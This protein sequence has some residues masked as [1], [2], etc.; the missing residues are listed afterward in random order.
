MIESLQGC[1]TALITPFTADGKEVDL[2]HLA[3]QIIFQADAKVTGIVPCGTTGE[4]PTHSL[5]EWEEVITTAVEVGHQHELM[6]IAGTGS[7][8]T[9]HA[10]DLQKRACALGGDAG[11]SV[12]PYYNKPSQEGMYYHFM[13]IA[14]AVDLPI[15]LYNIPGRSGVALTVDTILRLAAHPNIIAV[16]DAT[17]SVNLTSQL[18]PLANEKKLKLTVLSGDDA[19]TLPLASVGARGVISVISNI[20]P[21]AM[22]ELCKLFLNNKWEEARRKHQQLEPVMRGLL[23]LAGNPIPVKAAMK[24]MGRDSGVLRLPMYADA[25]IEEPL[26]HLLR[27]TGLLE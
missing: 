6:V 20:L 10:V 18:V 11:L 9:T 12:V 23:S 17:G 14:D 1:Y 16:K 13:T 22:Q 25:S 8:N 21:G 7:N 26:R 19:L 4:S 27:G 5:G 24:I 15:V 3:E 2:D